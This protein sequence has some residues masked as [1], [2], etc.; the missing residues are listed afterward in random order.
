MDSNQLEWIELSLD[1][2]DSDPVQDDEDVTE[3]PRG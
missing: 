1:T 3:N 2:K